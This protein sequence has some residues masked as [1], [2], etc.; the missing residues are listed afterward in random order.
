VAQL[1]QRSV[2]VAGAEAFLVGRGP[3]PHA[4]RIGVGTPRS[5]DELQRA[6]DVI[7]DALAGGAAPVASIV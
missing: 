4:V 6:L 1:R 7:A 3:V 2:I 5:R